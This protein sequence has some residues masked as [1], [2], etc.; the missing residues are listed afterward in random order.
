VCGIGGIATTRGAGELR[1]ALERVLARLAHRGPDDEGVHLGER[2][3]TRVAMCA[4]RLAIRDLSPRGH[5]PM[6]S[7]ATGRTIVF[8]GELYNADD[9]R[10]ELTAT[11]RVFA[12][13]SDTEVALAAYDEWG[14]AA[15]ARFRGMFALGLW[16]PG[17]ESLLLVRDPL[18]IKPLYY[19]CRPGRLAFAS[20]LRA[21]APAM[22]GPPRLSIAA[23]D[24]YLAEGAPPEPHTMLEDVWM[25]APGTALR[26][27]SG[28]ARQSVFWSLD[29]QFAAQRLDIGAEEASERIR[30]ELERAVREQLVADVPV[31]VFLSGGI[32][33]SALV[34]LS[35]TVDRPPTTT[36]V[37]FSEPEY[38]EARYIDAVARRWTTDHREVELSV[39]DF[40][41]R[42]PDALAAMDQ[43]TV[44]GLNSFVVSGLARSAGLTVALSGLGGD[45]LFAGYELFR[46]V[47]RLERFRRWSPRIPHRVGAPIVR[48]RLGGGDRAAKL[49]RW[50]EGEPVSA[51]DLQR[52]VLEPAMRARLL[53]EHVPRWDGQE[54]AAADAND[55]SRLELS[56]YMRNTLLR[57][58]DVMSMAHGLEVRVPL[59]DQGL[60]EL[61][62]RIPPALKVG[63]GAKPLLVRAVHDLLPEAVV[64]RP[65]MGFTFPFEDWLRGP[66]R[67]DVRSVLLDGEIGGEVGA[68]LDAGAVRS[69]WERFERRETS[70]SRPWALYAA[71]R[72]GE[73]HL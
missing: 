27:A 58:A 35:A 54:G 37:V 73:R 48:A 4:T 69:I 42:L 24:G 2:G 55:V 17:D 11:G 59:L 6:E 72:W 50:L 64:D 30:G 62:A 22:E 21:L 68:A 1:P 31:G 13:L 15:S 70:W 32:D 71:K 57:D 61:L 44:D 33:S 67:D 63:A 39:S 7:R 43:P 53:G 9:L 46:T 26:F 16:D 23:L 65:K 28:E 49:T 47:P 38:S 3:P 5:Q 41:A 34:G 51:Y 18:G 40:L 66:L 8:N 20:E 29:E 45:E 36:S 25:L 19:E 10:N 52:E 14:P 12:G 56:R 60:V